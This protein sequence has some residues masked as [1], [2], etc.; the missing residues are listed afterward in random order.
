MEPG[1]LPPIRS[2]MDGV[3]VGHPWALGGSLT[4][5]KD[6]AQWGGQRPFK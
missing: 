2:D 4:V 1:W 3:W 5:P 6:R